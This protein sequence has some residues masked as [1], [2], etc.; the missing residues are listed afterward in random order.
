MN[1]KELRLTAPG[2]DFAGSDIVFTAEA[3]SISTDKDY[4]DKE[5]KSRELLDVE[6]FPKITFRSTTVTK[7]NALTYKIVGDLTTSGQNLIFPTACI[8]RKRDRRKPY[9]FGNIQASIDRRKPVA[10]ESSKWQ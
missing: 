4:R 7:I 5:I 3:G 1:C 6:K 9:C 8:L 10:D 2:D